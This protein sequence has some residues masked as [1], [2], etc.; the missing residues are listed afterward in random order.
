MVE[1][2]RMAESMV[3]R[4]ERPAWNGFERRLRMLDFFP[5]FPFPPSGLFLELGLL[6]LLLG[7]DF[8]LFLELALVVFFLG[9][10]VEEEVDCCFGFFLVL[11]LDFSK[12]LLLLL[13][14]LVL[15][16]F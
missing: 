10:V 6:V 5:G 14:L 15:V 11:S 9:V 16:S 8:W 3:E 1:V 2:E 12:L 4:R 13:F 7:L